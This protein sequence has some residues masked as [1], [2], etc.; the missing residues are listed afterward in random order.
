MDTTAV[1]V[2]GA[3]TGI[4]WSI[5]KLLCGKGVRVFGSVRRQCDAERLCAEFGR[6]FSPLLFDIT[7][8]PAVRRAAADVSQSIGPSTLSG[9]VNNAGIAVP[10][11]LLYQPIADFRRQLEVNVTAQLSVIQAFAPL[12]GTDR[13]RVGEPGRIVNISSV[14]GKI[15]VPFVG[16]YA[17]SKHALEGLSGS[18]R[19]EL[20]L[21]GIDVIVVA[22]GAITTPIWD[23]AA[24]LDLA[25][26]TN[27]DYGPVLGK[28]RD[29]MIARGRRGLAPERVAEV[30]WRA[31]TARRPRTRYAVVHH[32]FKNWFLPRLLPAR[33]ID[34]AVAKQLGFRG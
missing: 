6:G 16:A 4:G 18:L 29:F 31:L 21:Y 34:R 19:R 20:M 7:D 8:E 22:P 11:P 2:T 1:V 3:S 24:E 23:K 28:F 26:Y 12:L 17:A 25:P 13:T 30:V 27:T 15:A 14:N 32:K 33:L 10:A 5:C 9:L